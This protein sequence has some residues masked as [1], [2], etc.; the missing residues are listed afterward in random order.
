MNA[1]NRKHKNALFL[2]RETGE[3]NKNPPKF[4]LAI[5]ASLKLLRPVTLLE[6]SKALQEI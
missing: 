1:K 4:N 5:A 3:S 2:K 6:K